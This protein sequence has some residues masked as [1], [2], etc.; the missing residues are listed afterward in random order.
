MYIEKE[1]SHNENITYRKLN[2]NKAVSEEIV[3]FGGF[4]IIHELM[5]VGKLDIQPQIPKKMKQDPS[6][7][8]E[9]SNYNEFKG[10]IQ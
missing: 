4:L 10:K 9:N 5:R 3:A 2:A 6:Q 7:Q 1:I 8:K